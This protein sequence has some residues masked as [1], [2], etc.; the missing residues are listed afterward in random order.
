MNMEIFGHSSVRQLIWLPVLVLLAAAGCAKR[1]GPGDTPQQT[2]VHEDRSVRHTVAA[3]ETLTRIAENYY[4]DPAAAERIARLNGITDPDRILPGSVLI[5]EFDEGQFRGARQRAVALEAYNRGVELMEQDRL[6][7][8]EDR[9]RL[10]L[11]TWPG[12]P[13]ASYNLALVLSRRGRHSEAVEILD[14]IIAIDPSSPD[15][16][17][18]RGHAQFSMTR[19]AEAADS[20]RDV[21]KLDPRHKR[22]AFS[23]ARCLQEDGRPAEA[24][25]AWE[26]YLEL[27]ETSSWAD[28][29][30]RNLKNLRHGG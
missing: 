10:A 3:G 30:R 2:V 29:A 14:G 22:A 24:I 12:M 6:A 13:S 21:L 7:Q 28:T 4:G 5:L 19:F 18:A 11:E 25:A 16:L 8:A 9:F 15:F 26:A 1:V 17:F 27:D 23:L 20:F